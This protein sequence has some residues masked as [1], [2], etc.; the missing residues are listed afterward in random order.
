MATRFWRFAY[1]EGA[2]EQIIGS[3]TLPF[4]DFARYPHAK[5]N[6]VAK[7]RGDLRTGHLVF[8]ANFDDTS[9]TGRIAAVGRVENILP[10][11]VEVTWKKVAPSRTV[12]PNPQ[13]G[14]SQW[15]KEAVFKFAAEP[16]KR[17]GLA[18]VAQKLFP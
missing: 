8:L 7:V 4:P 5:N 15:Q 2:L 14:V 9:L 12:S 16:A 6:S 10:D 11:S 13:G 17:Y 3:S 18:A 1:D